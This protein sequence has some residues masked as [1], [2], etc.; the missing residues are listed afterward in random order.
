LKELNISKSD[1]PNWKDALYLNVEV[2]VIDTIRYIVVW[3]SEGQPLYQIRNSDL[4]ARV[5]QDDEEA[6]IIP[7]NHT[8]PWYWKR[9]DE[10]FKVKIWVVINS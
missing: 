9:Y 5:N 4:I 3:N 10:K 7:P 6:L 1:I 8:V 2:K